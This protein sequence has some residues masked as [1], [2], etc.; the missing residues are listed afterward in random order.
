VQINYKSK[1]NAGS[2]SNSVKIKYWK[3]KPL[4]NLQGFFYIQKATNH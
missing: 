3:Q 1:E 4:Q 2:F